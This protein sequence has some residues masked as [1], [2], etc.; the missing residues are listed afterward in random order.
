MSEPVAT[1][2]A[3]APVH[4]APSTELRTPAR[5]VLQGVT[6][7][8]GDVIALNN[9]DLEFGPGVTGLLGSN[10]AGK[11]TMIRL[12]V[13]LAAADAGSVQLDGVPVRNHVPTLARIGYVADGDGLYEENTAREF[14]A[15][16]ARLRGVP[17]A[18]RAA[19]VEEII[20][21]VGLG[22]AADQRAGG[23]S[24][25]MRQRLKLGQAILH[26]PDVLILDEPLTGLDPLMRRDVIRVVREL[27]DAGA[28]VIVSSHVLHEIEAMTDRVVFMRHGQVL[29]EGTVGHIRDL[30]HTEPRRVRL[31]TPD[32]ADW[33]RRL[34]TVN[35]LVKGLQLE[36]DALLVITERPEQLSALVQDL[37]LDEQLALTGLQAVD[38]DLGSLF[39]YLVN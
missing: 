24:K 14:L 7:W 3:N 38:E 6:R 25:G 16:Q 1:A 23:Y 26:D 17:S 32:P 9:V 2:R 11:T 4:R 10:G 29:A 15:S 34:L 28:T 36:D 27:G 33:A 12:M 13:G 30:L 35:G 39:Q 8:F 19:L 37:V 21:R 18:Q 5:L 20:A 22:D 31:L